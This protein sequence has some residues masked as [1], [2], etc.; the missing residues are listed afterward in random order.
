VA[1]NRV[2][3]T[4]LLEKLGVTPQR[5][6]QLVGARKNELP[7]S[8][9]L[10]VYTIAFENR[11]DVSKELR[12]EETAEV[13]ALVAQLRNG[14]QPASSPTPSRRAS[15]ALKTASKP[16][17]LT[18]ADVD[19]G[20]IPAL[21]PLHAG[22]AKLMAEKVYPLI[23]I[24][25]NS[26]RDLIER[27][28]SASFGPKWWDTAVPKGP[29]ET[30]QRHLDAEKKDPW[31]SKRGRRPVDYVFLNELWAII[32]HHWALFAPLFPDQPWV[33]TMITRDMNVS[34]LVLAHMNPLAGDDVKALEVSFRKWVRQLKAVETLI[35]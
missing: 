19:F 2:I 3:K 8:T 18:I 32:K 33:Q 12:K 29:R 5:L 13:R 20:D 21:R 27:V 26:V 24:F 1:T 16:V 10:A 6:S 35:P 22:E 11:I 31:H 14:Q 34:R 4:A 7:M 23:Y 25:E 17:K 15:T 28:V 30:A 9:E